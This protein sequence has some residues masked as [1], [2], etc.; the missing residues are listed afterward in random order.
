MNNHSGSGISIPAAFN[1][2]PDNGVDSL[3]DPEKNFV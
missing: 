3:I 1:N 2:H